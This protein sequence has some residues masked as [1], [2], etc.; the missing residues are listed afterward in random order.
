MLFD[1]D[2]DDLETV[3]LFD[4][5]TA[6]EQGCLENILCELGAINDSTLEGVDP[7]DVEVLKKLDKDPNIKTL[8]D[9]A[10]ELVYGQDWSTPTLSAILDNPEPEEAIDEGL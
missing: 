9:L 10:E 5:F 6:E 7:I 3:E 2:N 8:K 4:R 1:V